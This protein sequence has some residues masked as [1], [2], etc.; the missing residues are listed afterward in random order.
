MLAG[1]TRSGVAVLA[2]LAARLLSLVLWIF[3]VMAWID[4]WGGPGLIVGLVTVP[5]V[6]VFPFLHWI[7]ENH[8]PWDYFAMWAGMIGLFTLATASRND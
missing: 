1:P 4:W 5:G 2:F 7:V 8:F 6:L 3:Y